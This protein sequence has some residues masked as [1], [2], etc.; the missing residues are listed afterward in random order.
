MKFE[1]KNGQYQRRV[2]WEGRALESIYRIVA[3]PCSRGGLQRLCYDVQIENSMG[4]KAW[5][6]SDH[7]HATILYAAV[8]DMRGVIDNFTEN[9]TR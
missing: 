7:E 4:E 3:V 1:A 2:I 9:S 5:K 6:P 8:C